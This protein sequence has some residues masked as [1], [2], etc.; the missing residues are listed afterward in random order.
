[1][2][3]EYKT[4]NSLGDYITGWAT[5]HAYNAWSAQGAQ[6]HKPYTP[7]PLPQPNN[8]K[9]TVA[10]PQPV[11]PPIYT[12]PEEYSVVGHHYSGPYAIAAWVMD[13]LFRAL[14]KVEQAIIPY[15]WV[16]A[17]AAALA[18]AVGAGY[19]KFSVF[20]SLPLNLLTGA[21]LGVVGAGLLLLALKVV[22]TVM[23]L[24]INVVMSLSIFGMMI[25]GIGALAA[26]AV[27]LMSFFVPELVV[28]FPEW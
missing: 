8:K 1:M 15:L 25:A 6:H 4:D 11:A 23:I 18:G 22:A 14:L 10:P 5:G 20:S 16:V 19:L 27:Y 26:A 2:G 28:L 17:L 24:A 12:K 7:P 3:T 9:Q 21:A 13:Q